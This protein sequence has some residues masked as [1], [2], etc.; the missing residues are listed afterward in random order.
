MSRELRARFRIEVAMLVSALTLLVATVIWRDWIET[1]FG[2]DP[3]AGNGSLERFIVAACGAT[4][5]LLLILSSREWR[6][7]PRV[8]GSI[9]ITQA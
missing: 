8:E 2:V 7:S 5:L 9:G 1:V 6:R 4:A 3:D